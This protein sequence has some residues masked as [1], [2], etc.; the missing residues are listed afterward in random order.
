MSEGLRSNEPLT[1]AELRE[2]FDEYAGTAGV[3][4]SERDTHWAFYRAGWK[5]REYNDSVA[6]NSMTK[7]EIGRA[8]ETVEKHEVIGAAD[9]GWEVDIDP[10][11]T[12]V[13]IDQV[14]SALGLSGN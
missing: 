13:Y 4:E 6:D 2:Q 10:A 1:E 9:G 5:M 12:L 14:R 8:L 3:P 7:D 11:G